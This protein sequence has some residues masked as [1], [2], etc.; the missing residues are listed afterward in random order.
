MAYRYASFLSTL[1]F[2]CCMRDRWLFSLNNI[3][4]LQCFNNNR[5]ST[6]QCFY[7]GTWQFGFPSRVRSD[8]DAENYLVSIL[9]CT[10]RSANRGSLIPDR[11]VINQRIE[12]LWRDVFWFCVLTFYFILW[13]NWVYLIR[14]TSSV[15]LRY[16]LNLYPGSTTY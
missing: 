15:C 2:T 14:L 9:M 7:E 6:I 8:R 12:Q 3:N 5:A 4:Y 16:I 1:A 10:I 13:K 11:S